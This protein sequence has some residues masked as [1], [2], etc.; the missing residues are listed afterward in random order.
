MTQPE[1]FQ[2]EGSPPS[3][4]APGTK[5]QALLRWF[6]LRPL[7]YGFIPF[8]LGA[9]YGIHANWERMKI[10]ELD[11]WPYSFSAW[12]GA[13]FIDEQGRTVGELENEDYIVL[14]VTRTGR[15]LLQFL[16]P[17]STEPSDLSML[18]VQDTR[19]DVAR[20]M[21]TLEGAS[22]SAMRTFK[23]FEQ[24]ESAA[25]AVYVYDDVNG[26]GRLDRRHIHA[27]DGSL[28]EEIYLDGSWTQAERLSRGI[29]RITLEDGSQAHV[30][31][32]GNDWEFLDDASLGD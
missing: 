27:K 32:G 21:L 30:R 8:L 18:A 7:I 3:T 15:N 10:T 12:Y 22:G 24:S 17:R 13:F 26:S 2:P 20:P 11:A 4:P 9:T 5:R 16:Q 1:D 25:P 14:S 29:R 6:V 28:A 23:V 31:W 19:G